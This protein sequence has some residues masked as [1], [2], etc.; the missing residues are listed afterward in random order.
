MRRLADDLWLWKQECPDSQREAF[1]FPDAKG[2][3]MDTGNYR[4][5]VLEAFM[6]WG[7]YSLKT[8]GDRMSRFQQGSL[9]KLERKSRPDVWVFRWYE[10]TSGKRRY[11]KQI[12]GTVIELRNR[13]E[14]EKAIIALRS[15][16]NAEIGTPKSVCDLAAHYRKHEL[17]PERKAFSTIEHHTQHLRNVCAVLWLFLHRR[18]VAPTTATRTPLY[19][20]CRKQD[21]CSPSSVRTR[22]SEKAAAIGDTQRG[23]STRVLVAIPSSSLF[24]EPANWHG[25]Y[26]W[27]KA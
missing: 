21:L 25:F 14:A 8:I 17:T 18:R 12:I 6:R 16:I 1:F 26:R 27:L 7:L 10:S 11:K 24:A 9:F 4:R 23:E 5:R 15:S 22:Q 13:G 20:P 2:G 3:F 19:R